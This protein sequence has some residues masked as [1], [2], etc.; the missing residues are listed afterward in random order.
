VH[1]DALG[2]IAGSPESAEGLVILNVGT[3]LVG[4]DTKSPGRNRLRLKQ[5]P[6]E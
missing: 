2:R 5:L 3:P 4:V 6:M 1:A